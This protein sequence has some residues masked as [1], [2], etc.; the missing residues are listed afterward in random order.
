MGGNQGRLNK[1]R[2]HETR[3]KLLVAA[4]MTAMVAM[5]LPPA[6]S[7]SRVVKTRVEP[8][9]PDLARMLGITGKVRL[10]VTVDCIGRVT[11][12]Q[13]VSGESMLAEAAEDAVRR[14]R[15]TSGRGEVLVPVE[16]SFP[17]AA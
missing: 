9:Y 7:K 2:L 5:M 3:V 16:L 13:T 11:A 8:E 10:A 12:V 17:Q 15:F 6:P 14:W 1:S 4:A